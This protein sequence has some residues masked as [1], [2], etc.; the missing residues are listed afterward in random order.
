L[1]GVTIPDSVTSIENSAFRN[2]S[3]LTVYAPERL[4]DRIWHRDIK[5]VIAY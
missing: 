1:T 4:V 3:S 2:C 5:K